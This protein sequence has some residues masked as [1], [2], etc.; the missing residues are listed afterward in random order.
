MY[1]K[2][3][4]TDDLR[5]QIAEDTTKKQVVLNLIWVIIQSNR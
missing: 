4:I 5:E 2:K 3:E 1:T